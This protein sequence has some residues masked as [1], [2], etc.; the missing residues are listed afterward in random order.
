MSFQ[1]TTCLSSALHVVSS[2]S[3][4]IKFARAEEVSVF[5]ISTDVSWKNNRNHFQTRPLGF[6]WV[7]RAYTIILE[8]LG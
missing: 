2:H 4:R 7:F 5:A 1:G 8:F 6:E 3:A